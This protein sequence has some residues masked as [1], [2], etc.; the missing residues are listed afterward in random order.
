MEIEF[1]VTAVLLRI[2]KVVAACRDAGVVLQ[3]QV[4]IE[5][6]CPGLIS[7]RILL[8]CRS[9]PPHVMRQRVDALRRRRALEASSAVDEEEF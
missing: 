5:S 9:L 1:F 8:R 3:A 6:L 2:D 7:Y 4:S